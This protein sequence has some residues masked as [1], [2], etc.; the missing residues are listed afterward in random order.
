[1]QN[2]IAKQN[3]P[4]KVALSPT[5]LR[6]KSQITAE[7]RCCEILLISCS[8]LPW[9]RWL[10]RVSAEN[11][12]KFMNVHASVFQVPSSLFAAATVVCACVSTVKG[13]FPFLCAVHASRCCD[14][15]IDCASAS[16]PPHHSLT[17]S[18][19]VGLIDGFA[20]YLLIDL[21]IATGAASVPPFAFLGIIVRT[22]SRFSRPYLDIWNRF[23]HA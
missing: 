9:P 6:A 8:T 16:T 20:I 4:P 22:R 5:L 23:G 21:L 17:H 15:R 3:S 10:G 11:I 14:I 19:Q 18:T 13:F 2:S 1:M 12:N 7:V